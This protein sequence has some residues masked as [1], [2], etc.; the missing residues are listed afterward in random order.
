MILG[1]THGSKG[2]RTRVNIRGTQKKMK[3]DLQ[4]KNGPWREKE[5]NLG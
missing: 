5:I 3:V 4:G 2:T 1:K